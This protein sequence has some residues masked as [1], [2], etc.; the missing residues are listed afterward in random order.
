MSRRASCSK[1][2]KLIVVATLTP[3]VFAACAHTELPEQLATA[4]T[5][6]T[7][8][9]QLKI[10]V[11][12]DPSL[13]IHEPLG[14]YE[15]LNPALA[16]MVRDALAADFATVEVV[17]DKAR[18]GD[19]DVIAIPVTE[20]RWYAKMKLTVTFVEPK[21]G[22]IL[23]ELSSAKPFDPHA[24]GSY[25]HLGT[26]AALMVPVFIVP[27]AVFLVEPTLQR[28]DADRFNARFG[29]ALV[30]MA[31]DVADQASKDQTLRS[32]S[33]RPQPAPKK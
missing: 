32:L 28:H 15:K 21:T 9:L 1:A 31:N 20:T 18:A 22:Q 33:S 25:D 16:D 3:L 17:D 7:A 29:P 27:P 12:A 23:A 19:A 14:F 8:K 30:A 4:A 13:T 26:D 2:I 24:P 6:G 11:V 10:A 5:V